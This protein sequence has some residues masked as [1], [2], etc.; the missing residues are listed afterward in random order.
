M[1][2]TVMPRL[3]CIFFSHPWAVLKLADVGMGDFYNEVLVEFAQSSLLAPTII[4]ED[5]SNREGLTPCL[6][7][8]GETLQAV[9]KSIFALFTPKTP[10]PFFGIAENLQGLPAPLVLAPSPSVSSVI[11]ISS[12]LSALAL[13]SQAKQ[14]SVLIHYQEAELFSGM[15]PHVDKFHFLWDIAD[16]PDKKLLDLAHQLTS[17]HYISTESWGGFHLC[18]SENRLVFDKAERENQYKAVISQYFQ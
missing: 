11:Q 7:R 13:P 15:F 1:S 16:L 5:S 9:K 12:L 18:H 3:R 4:P 14:I 10:D 6:R 17:H 8:Y 2:S